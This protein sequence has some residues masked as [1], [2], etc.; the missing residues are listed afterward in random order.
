M[1]ELRLNENR[2]GFAALGSV[3][4]NAMTLDFF[5]QRRAV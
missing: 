3:L 2:Y 4:L 1:G 5:H